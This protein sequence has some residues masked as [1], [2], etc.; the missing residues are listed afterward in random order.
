MLSRV[1]I[2]GEVSD[3]SLPVTD[4]AVLRG[5]GCFEVLLAVDGTALDVDEHL[6]RLE[7]SADRLAI[8]LPE[9]ER[10]AEWVAIVT[11]DVPNGAVRILATRGPSIPGLSG[12][13]RVVVF[14]HEWPP[15]EGGVE[16]L[17]VPA[18][19]HSAGTDWELSG[20]KMLS[21][22]PNLSATR[23]AR[24][25]GFHD[26]L[27]VD[28]SET[29]LEGPTFSVAWVRDGRLETP[30]VDLGI[31]DSITRRTVIDLAGASSIPVEEGV[32]PLDRMFDA[33]EIF[34]MSTMRRV[35]PVVRVE[36][37]VFEAGPVTAELAA[38]LSQVSGSK[39]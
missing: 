35:Q 29:L 6:S 27:L 23:T 5:D 38:A 22:A 8:S 13:P 37:K 15:I 3:G 7:K 25:K 36:A 24:E 17:P 32:W 9:R 28:R 19:W 34:V 21:Y 31:L 30:S 20:V 14:A 12:S 4:S 2:D 11:G 16:L 33:S 18:P 26:A 1:L 39:P 10:I